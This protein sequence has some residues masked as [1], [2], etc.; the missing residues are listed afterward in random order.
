MPN[1]IGPWE[2]AILLVI[3][4]LVFGPKRLPE[5][6]SSLGKAITGFK[7]GIKESEQEIRKAVTEESTVAQASETTEEEKK[8]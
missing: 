6:G 4:L 1:W 5:L 7:K 2:I 3:V 8:S